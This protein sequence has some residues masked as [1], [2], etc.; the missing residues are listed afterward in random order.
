MDSEYQASLK[1]SDTEEHIDIFFYRPIG[2]Q[3]ARLFRKL[4]VTPNVVTI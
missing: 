4:G 1:S 3:W 2:Y